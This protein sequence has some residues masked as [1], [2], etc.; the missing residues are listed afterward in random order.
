MSVV[1]AKLKMSREAFVGELTTRI[2]LGQEMLEEQFQIIGQER[3]AWG[4]GSRV[5]AVY[6]Q[7]KLEEYTKKYEKWNDFNKELLKQA[8]DIPNSSYHADYVQADTFELYGTGDV[9]E[10]LKSTLKCKLTNLESLAEKCHMIETIA[11]KAVQPEKKVVKGAKRVFIVH[12]HDTALRTQVELFIKNLGYDPIVLFKEADKGR[13]IIEKLENETDA[14]CYAIVLYTS[15]DLG[16][17]KEDDDLKPRAR[18]NVVFEHGYMNAKIGRNRV[19]ALLEKG[20]EEPGDLSGVIY[21]SVDDGGL[22]QYAL[23][24]EM[25]AAG[26][27]IDMNNVKV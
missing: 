10:D 6:D 17:A 1:N 22:W 8:F 26:L 7:A 27:D 19:C 11:I 18:Q 16:K 23:A 21:K 12:G 5:C 13:T 14:V 3:R 25:T 15:C 4:L 2:K 24:K 9:I 20:V